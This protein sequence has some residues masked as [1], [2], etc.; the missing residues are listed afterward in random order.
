[1]N[2]LIN[3]FHFVK[4][5]E[6]SLL[7]RVKNWILGKVL[8]EYSDSPKDYLEDIEFNEKDKYILNKISAL[9][10]GLTPKYWKRNK[11]I[12]EIVRNE[13][14]FLTRTVL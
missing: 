3:D 14:Y 12:L 8:T 7:L 10:S 2:K 4:K 6:Y 5:Q 9:N 13:N 1:M 11:Q